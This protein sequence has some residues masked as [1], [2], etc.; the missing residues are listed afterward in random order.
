[1][2]VT[3]MTSPK[4]HAVANQFI[5]EEERQAPDGHTIKVKHFQS[6]KSQIAMIYNIDES[7]SVY[8]DRKYWKYSATT[9]KYRS[10]F[11]NES[12]AETQAKIDSGEYILT[13]LN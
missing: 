8:L 12:T 5:I 2:R 11:L 4:G 13:N 6:Y 9:S 7:P 10:I 1:M 3:N